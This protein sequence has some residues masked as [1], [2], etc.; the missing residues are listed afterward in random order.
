MTLIEVTLVIMVL[1]GLV[2]ILFWGGQAFKEAAQ[3]QTCVMNIAQ[4]QKAMRSYQNMNDL[5]VGDP[6]PGNAIIGASRFFEHSPRCPDVEGTYQWLSTIP[7][8]GTACLICD[9]A[10]TKQHAPKST[11]GW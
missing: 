5:R 4:A 1:L 8:A 6:L 9:L 2:G 7:A 3:R 10:L 11:I